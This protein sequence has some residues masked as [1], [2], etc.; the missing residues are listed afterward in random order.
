MAHLSKLFSTLSRAL[1]LSPEGRSFFYA[2]SLMHV[3][4]KLLLGLTLVVE[5]SYGFRSLLAP[6]MSLVFTGGDLITC[7]VFSKLL[8]LCLKQSYR[9]A[10]HGFVLPLLA[11][12]LG[13][14]FIV[15]GHLKT[16]VNRGLLEFN[17]AGG[18]EI[19][20]YALAGMSVWAIAF[21]SIALFVA[22]AYSLAQPQLL[23]S[24]LVARVHLPLALVAL[25]GCAMLYAG[26][27]S[28]GQSGWLRSNPTYELV[29]T[30]TL[31]RAVAVAR[32]TPAE[33][34]SFAT[35]KP[36][37]GRY[38]SRLD[39]AVPSQRGKNVLFVLIES[40]PFEQTPLGGKSEGLTVLSELREQGVSFSNFRTVFPA[41]SRSFLTYHCG[42]HPT[43]GDATVTKYDPDYR[44]DSLLDSLKESGYRTG[45][46]TAPM[47]T[48]DNLHKAAMMKSYDVYEDFLT[49][50]ERV[51]TPMDAP[52]VAEEVVA[53]RLL[54][55]VRDEREKPFFAT[56]FMFWNHAPY[57]LPNED[58][59]QLPPY[60]RYERT[61]G[62]LDRVLRDLLAELR[63]DGVLDDTVVVVAADH[64]EG[65]A[66]HHDNRNHVGH[67]FEDDVHIPLLVH[68][69][70]LGRHETARSGSNVDFAPTLAALLELPAKRSWQ[71]QD[72]LASSYAPRPT[73]LFGRASFATNGIVDGNY[74]YIEYLDSGQRFLFDLA[75]DPHEQTN[76]LEPEREKADAY[77]ELIARW[78]PVVDYRG[79]A[80]SHEPSLPSV[81]PASLRAPSPEVSAAE[82]RTHPSLN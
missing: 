1:A 76:V 46:F 81:M 68:V 72:L 11:L 55:F 31:N 54:E 57:R 43:A 42:V 65:F 28:A 4:L 39:V 49:L 40:L 23:R 63:A 26:Q 77:R 53:S 78:L 14:N 35:P 60:E 7:F 82:P 6:P 3:A 2:T 27:L 15:H 58:I 56:Y 5:D 66:L 75:R 17:G 25:G 70:G 13:A 22:V 30:Y 18:E 33:A 73:L 79:W 9:R 37:F 71:G 24:P 36:L 48:Y 50:R 19:V 74:K 10:V 21:I 52:A 32:A 59:S 16:F 29:R 69:P 67:I 34:R 20:D 61:L 64:G 8:D 38:D 41:T 44:C 51:D 62:Y 47:F 12:F 45:F 80:V